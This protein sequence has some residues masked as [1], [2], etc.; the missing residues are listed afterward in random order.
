MRIRDRARLPAESTLP[1][2][3]PTV[4]L[5][6]AES[7]RARDAEAFELLGTVAETN[8][9]PK[10]PTRYY[11]DE[12]RVLGELQ[13]MVERRQQNIGADRYAGR[14]RRDSRSRGHQR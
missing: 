3:L 14:A 9:K 10:P 2:L 12:R 8:S 7:L 11:I 13:R 6:A 1:H 4:V 5:R